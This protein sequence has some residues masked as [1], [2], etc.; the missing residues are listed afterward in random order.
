MTISYDACTSNSECMDK[1]E[2]FICLKLP[3]KDGPMRRSKPYVSLTS[4][5]HVGAIWNGPS[6]LAVRKLTS[7][8]RRLSID[9][10][11]PTNKDVTSNFPEKKAPGTFETVSVRKFHQVRSLGMS[12]QG[13]YPMDSRKFKHQNRESKSSRNCSLSPENDRNPG[14]TVRVVFIPTGR[15]GVASSFREREPSCAMTSTIL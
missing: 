15:N 6:L 4:W 11:P 3:G 2:I 10:Y 14:Q 12:R 7:S 9:E 1:S 5:R 13:S 8:G